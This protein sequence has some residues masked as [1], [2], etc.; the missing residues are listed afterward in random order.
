MPSLERRDCFDSFSFSAIDDDQKPFLMGKPYWTIWE[1][2]KPRFRAALFRAS[3]GT[4]HL[5]T[6]RQK[7]N[8]TKTDTRKT[9]NQCS[10]RSFPWQRHSSSEVAAETASP[11][12][13]K[14]T[15][16]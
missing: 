13:E 1:E 3:D 10:G 9:K 15:R 14:R 6:L 16:D 4:K 11:E 2:D 12:F 8:E 5:S 7:Q